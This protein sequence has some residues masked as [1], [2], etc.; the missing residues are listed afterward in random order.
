MEQRVYLAYIQVTVNHLS[1][2]LREVKA[3]TRKI[4]REEL[5]RGRGEALLTGF[6]KCPRTTVPLTV[7]RALLH[8]SVGKCLTV[9]SQANLMQIFSQLRFCSQMAL[10]YVKLTK[11]KTKPTTKTKIANTSKSACATCL[12][13]LLSEVACKRLKAPKVTHSF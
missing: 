4:W 11:N 7:S 6:L 8:Q 13:L 2:P 1:P 9:C 5:N 10:A 12:L 3:G